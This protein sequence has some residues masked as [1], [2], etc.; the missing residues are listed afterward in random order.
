MA[1]LGSANN[2][3]FVEVEL[4]EMF[5]AL[6]LGVVDVLASHATH[7]MERDVFEVCM[8]KL[9]WIARG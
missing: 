7:T 3:E 5:V 1:A 4:K 6:Q 8:A 9:L 2:V